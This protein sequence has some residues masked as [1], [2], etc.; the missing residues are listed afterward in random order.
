V[1]DRLFIDFEVLTS[2]PTQIRAAGICDVLSIATGSWDWQFA[3]QKG[4][5][6]P[7]MAYIPYVA[8]AA[9]AILNGV[10]DCAEAAGR[11]DP[12]GLKQLLD[13]LALEVQL[14]NQLG[15]A[16]PEEG[17]EHYFAYALEN[18]VG[19]GKPHADL[20]GPGILIMAGFQGQETKPLEKAMRLCQAPLDTLPAEAI[21]A[22]LHELPAY[23]RRHGLPYTIAHELKEKL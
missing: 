4:M 19:A 21:N 23:V 5:N 15:H 20:L 9:Q 7:D 8:Q 1:P 12:A 16:C 18:R 10:L 6:E 3:E 13:C 17:S 22:T 2:A 11:G 14:C